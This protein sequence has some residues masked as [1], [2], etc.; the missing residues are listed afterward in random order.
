MNTAPRNPTSGL[1][2][3]AIGD[4]HGCLHKL[5]PLLDRCRHY[6]GERPTRF[7]FLGDYVDRG[8]DSRGVIEAVRALERSGPEVICLRGN[9]EVLMLAAYHAYEILPW[10]LNGAMATLESYGVR[11]PAALPPDHIEWLDSLPY[12]FDDGSRY[13]V[14]AGVNP[15]LPLD[16]QAEHDL[17]WIRE[18]FLQSEQSFGRL[19]VHGHTPVA[20]GV[21]DLRPNRLNLDTGAVLGGPLTA[22]V[23]EETRV[24]PVGYFT[25]EAEGF[26]R[27]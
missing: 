14:H 9:H 5:S 8:P 21:P 3:F 4:V 23:F 27:A 18:P 12:R 6:A 20:A 24:L 16:Q 26:A 13:F 7:V 15:L 11:E 1:I 10:M 2:T 22:A 17:V 25:N 19:I